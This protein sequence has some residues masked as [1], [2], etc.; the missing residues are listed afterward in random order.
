MLGTSPGI[1]RDRQTGLSG[2]CPGFLTGFSAAI[3]P[4]ED[5]AKLALQGDAVAAAF[6]AWGDHNAVDDL[7]NGVCGL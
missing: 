4:V 6:L 2:V 7:A 5:G 1:C 3:D